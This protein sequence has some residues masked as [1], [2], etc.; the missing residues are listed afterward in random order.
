MSDR[1]IAREYLTP[2]KYGKDSE[3]KVSSSRAANLIAYAE[4]F[5]I[6]AMIN[7]GYQ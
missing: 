6:G 7:D 4:G 5:I 1:A 3:K 2:L